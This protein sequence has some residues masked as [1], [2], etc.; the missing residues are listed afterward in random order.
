MTIYTD[1]DKAVMVEKAIILN[2]LIAHGTPAQKKDAIQDW[3]LLKPAIITACGL[4]FNV[5][6]TDVHKDEMHFF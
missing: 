5:N 3:M 1:F 2:G 6:Q 4:E